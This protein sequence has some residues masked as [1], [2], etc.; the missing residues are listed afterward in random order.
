MYAIRNERYNRVPKEVTNSVRFGTWFDRDDPVRPCP[1]L[2]EFSCDGWVSLRQAPSMLTLK[3]GPGKALKYACRSGL[4]HDLGIT[5]LSDPVIGELTSEAL[6]EPRADSHPVVAE[7]NL[8]LKYCDPFKLFAK[9][10]LD[11]LRGNKPRDLVVWYG[12]S[13]KIT[14]PI[15]PSLL[16]KGGKDM[17]KGIRKSIPFHQIADDEVK[18]NVIL[19]STHW[20]HRLHMLSKGKASYL[21]EWSLML[22]RRISSLLTGQPDPMWTEDQVDEFYVTR[23]VRRRSTRS[24]RFIELLQTITG[25]FVQRYLTI[26]EE[27]WTWEKFDMFNL[28]NLWYLIGDEFFD[29]ELTDKSA[30]LTTY[31]KTLK[32][33]R[34]DFKSNI[35]NQGLHRYLK[36]GDMFHG[37][38]PL[39]LRSQ[40]PVFDAVLGRPYSEHQ[41]YQ[42]GLLSQSRGVGTPPMIDVVQS[43]MKFSAT[44]QLDAIPLNQERENAIRFGMETIC[45]NLPDYALTGL[46]TKAII[47]LTTS[48]CLGSKVSDGGTTQAI[49]DEINGLEPGYKIPIRDL[50]TGS[51]LSYSER[52]SLEMGERIFWHCIQRILE[53]DPRELRK[54][55]MVV[56]SEPG[57]SRCVTKGTAYLKVITD[58]VS[59][60]CSWPLK[61]GIESSTSGMSKESHGWEF[62]KSF[63]KTDEP[64]LFEVAKKDKGPAGSNIIRETYKDVYV[65]S[66]DYETATDY[67]DFQVA[68]IVADYWMRKCGIPL[69]LQGIVRETSYKPRY[70]TMRVNH[71]LRNIGVHVG[72][73]LRMITTRRGV[74]MGDPLTKP[75]LHLINV[76]TRVLSPL[77]YSGDSHK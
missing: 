63:F 8:R 19:R 9:R 36:D 53:T 61:K 14:D 18:L 39:W 77:E 35:S 17:E 38:L 66:T 37:E 33:S 31:Y 74:L 30:T 45:Q 15:P 44:L 68:E 48:A 64:N 10:E 59:K 76:L 43:Q 23:D 57:K 29:G 51:I 27:V 1:I 20:G 3:G 62:F 5:F 52:E 16:Q 7:D 12:D 22:I 34:K 6:E 67:L 65:S 56:I 25:V 46:T 2:D 28:K 42:I 11:Q 60:I 72:E 54:A 24:L 50:N 71:P 58:V 47:T 73:N 75:V 41:V 49:S 32:R 21:K 4:A 70:I 69:I 55:D 40:R 26:P 13:Y